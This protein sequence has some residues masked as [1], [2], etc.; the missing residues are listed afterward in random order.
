MCGGEREGGGRKRGKRE[1]E[2]IIYTIIIM[3]HM[4]RLIKIANVTFYFCLNKSYLVNRNYFYL[5]N[6]LNTI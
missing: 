1:R 6:S 5:E 2:F 3:L 4:H